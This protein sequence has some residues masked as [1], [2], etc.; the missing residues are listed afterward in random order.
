M[1][2]YSDATSFPDYNLTFALEIAVF[3]LSHEFLNSMST[4]SL[5]LELALFSANTISV[6]EYRNQRYSTDVRIRY[7]YEN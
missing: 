6:K 5:L 1:A 7:F 4:C 2:A 3:D